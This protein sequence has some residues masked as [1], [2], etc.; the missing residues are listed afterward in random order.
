[1][2]EQEIVALLDRLFP[3]GFAGADVQQELTPEGWQASPLAR[4]FHPTVEQQWKEAVRMHRNLQELTRNRAEPDAKPEPTLDEIVRDHIEPVWE[5]ERE[6]RELVGLCLWDVFSDNHEVIGPDGR[7]ADTGSFRGSGGFI[8]DYLNVRL[9]TSQYDYIDFYMGTIWLVGRTDLF[10]VYRLIFQRLKTQGGAWRYHFPRLFVAD[11]RPLLDEMRNEAGRPEW[12][13]YS[14]S[15][16]IA[17]ETEHQR[18]DEELAR[19]R[20]ELDDAH[21]AEVER[22]RTHPPPTIVR[23]YEAAYGHFPQGWPPTLED[24]GD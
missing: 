17:Q 20:Q 12:K 6:L 2:Q 18:H 4:A 21:R 5:P 10:P 3:H 23:A 19:L 14:P 15:Q 9:G 22:A 8:A 7:V 1:M 13:T 11:M 24:S 16:A